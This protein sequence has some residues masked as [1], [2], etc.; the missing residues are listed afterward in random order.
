MLL[1][2]TFE[3]TTRDF[4][5]TYVL[6][7]FLFLNFLREK[8]QRERVAGGGWPQGRKSKLCRQTEAETKP[9]TINSFFFFWPAAVVFQRQW[10]YVL[11]LNLENK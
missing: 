10:G 11:N 1:S 9:T 4:G 2:S 3:K 5:R 8:P 6:N 7:F